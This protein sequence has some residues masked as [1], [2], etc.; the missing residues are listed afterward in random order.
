M[1]EQ[2]FLNNPYPSREEKSELG[3]RVGLG[4]DKV[5]KWYDN[6]RTKA[7]K[8]K[9]G[10]QRPLA[11]GAESYQQ[12]QQQQQ[13]LFQSVNRQ[14]LTEA[15][16]SQAVN[17]SQPLANYLSSL[18]Y[19]PNPTATPYLNVLTLQQL[20]STNIFGAASVAPLINPQQQ[21]PS[22]AQ[23]TA[24]T[25]SVFN[26]TA[27]TQSVTKPSTPPQPQPQ[28]QLLSAFSAVQSNRTLPNNLSPLTPSSF[29]DAT[30]IPSLPSTPMMHYSNA[31]VRPLSVIDSIA[32]TS[33]TNSPINSNTGFV[34][35]LLIK[36][37]RLGNE[38][39]NNPHGSFVSRS[40]SMVSLNGAAQSIFSPTLCQQQLPSQPAFGGAVHH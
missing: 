19:Q 39:A 11:T 36:R 7:N 16:F 27:M 22:Q 40:L 12:Q 35:P 18:S 17:P 34:S 29:I 30:S 4:V 13:P 28:P 8:D 10:K 26:Q 31:P 32:N 2:F 5:H 20:M 25:P 23:F 3:S 14:Q 9:R 24:L 38:M 37:Q 21:S 33:N 6:R 15:K 1:L